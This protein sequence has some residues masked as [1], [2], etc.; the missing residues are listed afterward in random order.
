[1][2]RTFFGG[3][4][5]G[6]GRRQQRP[7]RRS[8]L[9]LPRVVQ[10]VS[11]AAALAG[12]LV[13]QP[14]AVAAQTSQ[15]AASEAAAPPGQSAIRQVTI[16]QIMKSPD[17]FYG[18]DV[19]I[20]GGVDRA[21]GD[22]A[23]LLQDS[24]LLGNEEILVVAAKPI[25]NMTATADDLDARSADALV[26]Q[27]LEI[28]GSVNQFNAAAFED[29]LGSD[30]QNSLFADWSG[31]PAILAQAVRPSSPLMIAV[32]SMGE[33]A[34]SSSSSS[35]SSSTSTG[36]VSET[37]DGVAAHPT[38]FS[39]RTVTLGG[40]VE[41]ILG[42]RSFILED[43]DFLGPQRLLVV[44]DKPFR[45]QQGTA[46]PDA[47]TIGDYTQIAGT[48]HVFN[49]A[50]FEQQLGVSLDNS[51][52]D[53]WE[54]KAAMIATQVISANWGDDLTNS[55]RQ[56]QM[57]P[58]STP[59]SAATTAQASTAPAA[60]AAGLSVAQ[61]LESPNLYDGETRNIVGVV[62]EMASPVGFVLTDRASGGPE[63]LIMNSPSLQ[64]ELATGQQTTPE[65]NE[66][67]RITGE[68]VRFDPESVEQTLG[69]NLDETQFTDWT[70]R[71]VVFATNITPVTESQ[72]N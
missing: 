70:D 42:P 2:D 28:Q 37:I 59:A 50:A 38:A 19:R 31:R 14:V 21:I 72:S 66:A 34:S 9:R 33:S 53:Q 55:S 25:A 56:G 32:P 12:C 17:S 58:T 54:G 65:L 57:P 47:P 1:M 62:D 43:R 69:V 11:L 63:L 5:S 6:T 48:V 8:P 27:T 60:A 61:V 23:F 20:V 22:H 52:F 4:G 41:E 39:D 40:Y 3:T 10:S 45:N 29:R 13:V 15:P 44:T 36:Y 64:A 35:G 24:N 7:G 71:P 26:G 68:V 51:Q 30:L 16:E 49:S 18:Q 46:T 67:V